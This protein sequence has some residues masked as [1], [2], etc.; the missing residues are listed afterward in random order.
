MRFC[1]K[2]RKYYVI[3]TEAAAV[4]ALTT[5]EGR[6]S[7]EGSDMHISNVYFYDTVYVIRSQCLCHVFNV[8]FMQC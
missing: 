6:E 7:R 2:Q 3:K 4:T 8:L 5:G 1:C